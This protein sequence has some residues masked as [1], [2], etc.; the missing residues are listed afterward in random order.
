MARVVA[1]DAGTTGVRALALDEASPGHRCGLPGADPA[2]PPP[3]LG[4]A[5]RHRD[6]A[7]R[8]GHPGRGGRP[9]G[10]G[11]RDGGRHRHHQPARDAGRL[12]PPH[13]P[14]PP[15]G[16]R[17]A[18][19]AHRSPLPPPDG[20]RSSAAGPST[21]RPRARSVFQRHQG[22]LAPHRERAR[23]RP[24]R[25]RPLLLHRRHLGSVAPHR[26]DGRRHLRHRSLQRQPHSALRHRGAGLVARALR[27]LRRAGPHA[28]RGAPLS[29][30]LRH[31]S[32]ERPRPRRRRARRRR[33]LGRAR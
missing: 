19:P 21:D 15:P 24:G 3:G 13:R 25:P 11:R 22:R 30:A 10:R 9:P 7:G 5:R 26:R 6:L 33:R 17:L 14:A 8:P 12:R 20:G 1:I 2:L 27:P 28:G 32:A 18:G 16:H 29:R 4:R 31:C 23:S